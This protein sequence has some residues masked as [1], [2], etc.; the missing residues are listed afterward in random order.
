[1]LATKYE[2]WC[3]VAYASLWLTKGYALPAPAGRDER[4]VSPR[5]GFA[6]GIPLR[7]MPLG[8]SITY[9]LKSSD[10]NGYRLALRDSITAHGNEVNM[11]GT[12]PNGTMQD[13]QNEGWPGYVIDQVHD[14]ADTAVPAEKPNLVLINAGTNDCLQDDDV[15]GAGD[16]MKS[17]IND[18]YTDSPQATVILSTLLVNADAATQTR[19]VNSFNPQMSSL[20][21]SLQGAGK[22][23][24]LVDMQ[25]SAGPTLDELVDGT[26]PDDAGYKKMANI[27]YAGIQQADSKG[28]LVQAQAVAGIPDD[29]DS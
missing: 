24:V 18:I 27:W 16:R 10:G 9:G 7:I 12:H 13:N 26:H 6:N 8:A 2:L 20:A 28:F 5:A 15:A 21:N 11:V 29:G 22:R 3:F 19:I 1:M 17:M 14:K 25:S 23:I 4:P